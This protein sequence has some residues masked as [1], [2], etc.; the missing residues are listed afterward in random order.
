MSE[1]K[2]HLNVRYVWGGT[3]PKGFDCSGF[4]KYV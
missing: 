3:T 4:L 1:A 2:K